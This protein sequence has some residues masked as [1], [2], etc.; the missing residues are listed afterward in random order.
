[1]DE[2]ELALKQGA[3]YERTFRWITDAGTSSAVARSLVGYIWKAQ[4]RAKEDVS[5]TLLLDMAD[6]ITLES[7]GAVA[8]GGTVVVAND[9]LRLFIPADAVAALDYAVGFKRATAAWD[10]FLTPPAGEDRRELSV[11]GPATLDPAA[12]QT[13]SVEP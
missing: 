13:L 8:P 11:Q 3:F 5:S 9:R 1:M 10:L 6:L 4:I 2:L 7:S 12:T